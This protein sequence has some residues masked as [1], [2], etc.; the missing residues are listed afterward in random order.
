METTVCPWC[1]T[2]IVWD[3]EIGPED[4]CPHCDNELKGYRTVSIGPDD[5][6]LEDEPE[7]EPEDDSGLWDDEDREHVVPVY[8][9]LDEYREKYD[10]KR[11]EQRTSELLDQQTEAPECLQCHEYMLL[12]GVRAVEG[13]SFEPR[14]AEDGKL[15]V[16]E[17]PFMLNVYVCPSCF[18]VQ[19]SLSETSRTA[20][21]RNL[22]GGAQKG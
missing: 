14:L 8:R 3:E 2:E 22:S 21:V 15:P 20:F 13:S 12:S 7:E 4:T 6:E 11:Y 18:Q 5:L 16:L 9:T 10:L 19:H 1:H 17:A